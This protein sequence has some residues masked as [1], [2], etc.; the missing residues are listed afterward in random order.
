MIG[1]SFANI[2]VRSSTIGA[3]LS[4]T[5]VRNSSFTNVSVIV[6]NG[7]AFTFTNTNDSSFRGLNVSS[8]QRAGLRPSDTTGI[9][10]EGFNNSFVDVRVFSGGVGHDGGGDAFGL[11]CTAHCDL[12][13]FANVTIT[14]SNSTGL[15]LLN[16]S[17]NNVF[18]NLT[19]V[20]NSSWI[21]LSNGTS[22]AGDGNNI[23]NLA[24]E[25]PNTTVR[26]PGLINLPN[27]SL[28]NASNVNVSFNHTF[29]NT[30]NLSWLD[31]PSQVIF[32]DLKYTN[33][34]EM[35][36]PE[37]DGT[38]IDCTADICT[39]LSYSEGILLFN[40]TGWSA[41][42]ARE[43]VILPEQEDSVR[44]TPPSTA[45]LSRDGVQ[46]T[47]SGAEK[48]SVPVGDTSYIFDVIRT[49]GKNGAEIAFGAAIAAI[50]VGQTTLL[51]VDGDGKDDV[52][53]KLA[54]VTPKGIEV[55]IEPIL[56]AAPLQEP[57][58]IPTVEMPTAADE[59]ETPLPREE[60]GGMLPSLTA[61]VQ[62]SPLKFEKETPSFSLF[63][64]IAAILAI[65]TLITFFALHRK[66]LLHGHMGKIE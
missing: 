54:G 59:K 60:L 17:A 32:R 43:S 55:F 47:I 22:Q 37:G 58:S 18:Y 52:T 40:V 46:F 21:M 66:A 12:N 6:G 62:E 3:G 36:D 38:F 2:L 27:R 48:V 35:I 20:S 64:K 28:V 57:K 65:L 23:T 14:V 13:Y 19:I 56:A 30:T 26:F 25:M 45:P 41:Y 1:S 33:P 5:R 29:I 44:T 9:E 34:V 7:S 24:M 63:A 49:N 61:P 39:H 53:L 8:G 10:V 11:G 51:D 50:T 31:M 15:V 42:S 4:L 16:G